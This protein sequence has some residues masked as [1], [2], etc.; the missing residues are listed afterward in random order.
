MALPAVLILIMC[1]SYSPFFFFFSLFSPFFGMKKGGCATKSLLR[2]R[3]KICSLSRCGGDGGRRG[4][5]HA[6]HMKDPGKE[7]DEY[8]ATTK[9][10]V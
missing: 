5:I 3:V 9:E 8:D 2:G 6:A 1:G 4:F 10:G 7:K